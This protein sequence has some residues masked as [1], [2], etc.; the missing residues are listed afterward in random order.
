MAP[1][2]QPGNTRPAQ[3]GAGS[4]SENLLPADDKSADGRFDVAEEVNLDQ[5]SDKARHIGQAPAANPQDEAARGT[6]GA[7]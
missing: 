7:R 4:R 3:G 2:D 5:Q 6:P 1:S